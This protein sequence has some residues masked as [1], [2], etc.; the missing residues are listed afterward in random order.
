[1]YSFV[2]PDLLVEAGGHLARIDRAAETVVREI[3]IDA[4]QWVEPFGGGV[5]VGLGRA[6]YDGSLDL[7]ADN[8]QA[9]RAAAAPVVRGRRLYARTIRCPNVGPVR[10][11]VVADARTGKIL[12]RRNGPFAIGRIGG[13]VSVPGEDGCD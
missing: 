9:A 12:I 1:V 4:A 8:P 6:L 13:E 7:V 5:V 11:V 2:T 10:G 3:E